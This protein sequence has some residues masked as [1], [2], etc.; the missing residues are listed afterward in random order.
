MLTSLGFGIAISIA[1]KLAG[2][3]VPAILF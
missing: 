1:A 3:Q 2:L